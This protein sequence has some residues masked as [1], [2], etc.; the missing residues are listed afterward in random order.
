MNWL[1]RLSRRYLTTG[2][3]ILLGAAAASA[4]AGLDPFRTQLGGLFVVIGSLTVI[5]LIL[6]L[7]TR[8]R[9]SGQWSAPI[10]AVAGGRFRLTVRV[11]NQGRRT[12]Y[13]FEAY[14]D[15]LPEGLSHG[16]EAPE[17]R[18]D[19]LEPGA[20]HELR[21]PLWAWRRGA[22]D[23]GPVYVGSTYP[24]GLLRLGRKLAGQRRV[25]VTPPIHP[26]AQL[27]LASGLRYQPGGVPLASQTGES[28][29]F[30]GVREYRH[31]DSLR[32]LH[33][34]LWARR[35]EPVV[36]EYSQEYFSR[37]G[38]ILDTFKPTDLEPAVEVAASIAAYLERRDAIVDFFAAGETVYTLSAG[39]H[40]GA[41]QSILDVLA[42][43]TAC[44]QPPYA[45]LEA[46]LARMLAGLSAVV[47]V[48]FA[49]NPQRED[50]L[51]RLRV[52][53]A[54][55]KV[56]VIGPG[57]CPP[58]AVRVNPEEMPACLGRL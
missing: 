23:L 45:R 32:K 38:V 17:S 50:F 33:W 36:R 4:V 58:E 11:L 31:G 14:L 8:P 20:A 39:R 24:L 54:P 25:L 53:G 2:G 48:T 22:Y 55:L 47:V 26:I 51:E 3:R 56:I 40:V 43:V 35:G 41:L 28:M 12:A 18:H 13:D 7:L 29:E 15:R 49:L 37:V 30:V 34:K 6:G 1:R 19:L 46:Q 21:I 57:P 16:K 44:K 42:C 5:T 9:L 27:E 10:R 52:H